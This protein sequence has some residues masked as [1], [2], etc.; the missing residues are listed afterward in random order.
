MPRKAKK[1]QRILNAT[2]IQG[3]AYEVDGTLFWDPIPRI[4]KVLPWGY[5]LD[6]EDPSMLL[7]DNEAL[8]NLEVAKKLVKKYS[9]RQVALWLEQETGRP[10]SHITLHQRIR[11]EKER[12][13]TASLTK[14]YAKRAI[15]ALKRAEIAEKKARTL[16]PAGR[17][18]STPTGEGII[19]RFYPDHRNECPLCGKKRDLPTESG[20]SD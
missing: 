11:Y 3:P 14:I 16:K 9:L 4:S 13:R 10:I 20:S 6:P 7:P 12:G 15:D 18:E 8:R 5:D 19:K 2:E 17:R 1:P